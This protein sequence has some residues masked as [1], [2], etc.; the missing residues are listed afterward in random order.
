MGGQH[1]PIHPGRL[2]GVHGIRPRLW[3][4]PALAVSSSS[5]YWPSWSSTSAPLAKSVSR[6][7]TSG[8]PASWY[9]V[10]RRATR[11]SRRSSRPGRMSTTGGCPFGLRPH[12]PGARRTA[13]SGVAFFD[14]H[15]AR[16]ERPLLSRVQQT[17]QLLVSKPGEQGRVLEHARLVHA[18]PASDSAPIYRSGSEQRGATGIRSPFAVLSA[19]RARARH[20]SADPS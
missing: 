7:S 1:E 20:S 3:P 11:P 8:S 17:R 13:P 9:G 6:A 2:G 4:H 5:M 12:P 19:R 10:C 16:G 18:S 15:V 14:D